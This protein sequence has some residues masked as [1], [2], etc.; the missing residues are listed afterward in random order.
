M[1]LL[2]KIISVS[3]TSA[4]LICAMLAP[5]QSVQADTCCSAGII[6][7]NSGG[8]AEPA[9]YAYG[10]THRTGNHY[11]RYIYSNGVWEWWADNNGGSDGD[12]R[13]TFYGF[14]QC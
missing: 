11:V 14:R 3:G 6:T 1:R 13:D 4:R 7:I 10:H 9:S 5:V 8:G 2:H 12:T